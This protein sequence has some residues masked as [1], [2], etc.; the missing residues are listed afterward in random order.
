MNG[1]NVLK[2]EDPREILPLPP[3]EVTVR[4]EPSVGSKASPA[5]ESADTL[6]LDFPGFKT[7]R[8]VCCL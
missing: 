5:P 4:R 7:A 1:I 8:N 3:C 2:K 6:V